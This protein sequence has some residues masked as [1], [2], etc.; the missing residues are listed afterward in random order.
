MATINIELDEYKKIIRYKSKLDKLEKENNE[1]RSLIKDK[2]AQEV[3]KA[4]TKQ[5]NELNTFN[6]ELKWAI[7]T[8]SY[9]YKNIPKWIINIFVHSVYL[10]DIKQIINK[11]KL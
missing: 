1:L 5:V 9:L 10:K 11:Y 6:Y 4:L 3:I 2:D 8:I 7:I